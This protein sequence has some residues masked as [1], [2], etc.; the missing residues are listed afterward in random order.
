MKSLNEKPLLEPEWGDG[1]YIHTGFGLTPSCLHSLRK[2]GRIRSMSTKGPGEKYGKRLY[3]V[4]SVR[5]YLEA[6]EAL[7]HAGAGKGGAA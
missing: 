5:A 1:K 7:E 3:H 4:G 2:K 6:Q